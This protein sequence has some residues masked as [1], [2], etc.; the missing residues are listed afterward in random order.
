MTKIPATSIQ[1]AVLEERGY[2]GDEPCYLAYDGGWKWESPS[3]TAS[4]SDG[5]A[6]DALLERVLQLENQCMDLRH[7]AQLGDA[8]QHALQANELLDAVD[9]FNSAVP[10][11]MMIIGNIEPAADISE[12]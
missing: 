5:E 3:W 4:A 10:G 8:L 6:A 7:R 2:T 12:F 11:G 9:Q 1:R